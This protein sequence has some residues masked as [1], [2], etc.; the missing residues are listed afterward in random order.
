MQDELIRK[1]Q[2]SKYIVGLTGGIGSGK[3]TVGNLF[4]AKGVDTVDADVVAREVVAPNSFG[5]Q[6]IEQRFGSSII[7]ENGELNR[8]A[9]R[10]LVFADAS[11]KD[12]LNAIL[13][14]LIRVEMLNQLACTQSDYCLLIAPLLFENKLES[15]CNE[16]IAVDLSEQQQLSRAMARDGS[17]ESTIKGIMAAQIS[18]SE[19]LKKADYIVD[20]SRSLDSLVDQ[21]N[22]LHKKLMTK[23][24][25]HLK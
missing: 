24:H 6:A 18:R 20:N 5:L 22:D 15:L 3:T 13:H 11:A 21:V 2:T 16:S 10:E 9:L 1:L 17:N 25:L 4:A 19:R 8:Q 14:P 23:S 7:L 12:D